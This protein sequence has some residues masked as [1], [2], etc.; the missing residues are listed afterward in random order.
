MKTIGITGGTGLVG[1]VITR[2]LV[3]KGYRVIIFTRHLRP[4]SDG[5]SYAFW[6]A[7]KQDISIAALQ[8]LDAIIHLAGEGVADKRWTPQRKL[9][10]LESRT[11]GTSFITNKI[12][13][14]APNCKV[15]VGASA[16]GYYGADK[17]GRPFTETD[18]ASTDFLGSTCKAWEEAS[19]SIEGKIRRVLI[20][21]GIVL[22]T[23][24]GAFKE[25]AKPVKFGVAPLLGG[26]KQ[27]VSWIHIE[28]LAALFVYA[29]E[30]EMMQGVYNGVAPVPVAQSQLM[31]SIRKNSKGIS[32]PIPVPAFVLK[33]M[34]GE[35]SI[36]V[37]K[38]ATV[39]SNKTEQAGFQFQYTT[40]NKAVTA[41]LGNA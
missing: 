38:S 31:Y 13:Q 14:H 29:L 12:L 20:R 23:E 1:R 7:N 33:I 35:M 19:E 26:G 17:G 21:I 11:I 25:F 37:L 3:N 34:L 2:L 39:S 32:I 8:Q 41:L 5:V 15:F 16:I 40:I 22:S 10:I 27:T 30:N 24:G 6:D 4:E 18:N 36:E 9:Q 28:D